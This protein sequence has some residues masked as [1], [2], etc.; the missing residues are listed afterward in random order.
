MK[1]RSFL[2]AMLGAAVVAVVEGTAAKQVTGISDA[3]ATS[4]FV[5]DGSLTLDKLRDAINSLRNAPY[6]PEPVII[7]HPDQLEIW[8][9]SEVT[10]EHSN[11]YFGVGVL[12]QLRLVSIVTDES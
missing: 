12:E 9:G 7:M 4:T 5:D 8:K 3:W 1:R 2:K 11:R 10:I 6:P